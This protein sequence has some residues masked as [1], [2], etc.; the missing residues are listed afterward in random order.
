M[1]RARKMRSIENMV[2]GVNCARAKVRQEVHLGLT[3][4]SIY[5]PGYRA[6]PNKWRPLAGRDDSST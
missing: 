5:R 3:Y 1:A 4:V 6:P 2:Y